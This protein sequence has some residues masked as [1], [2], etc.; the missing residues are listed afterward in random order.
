MGTNRCVELRFGGP[1]KFE[2]KLASPHV[3][4]FTQ[5]I[6]HPEDPVQSYRKEEIYHL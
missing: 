4:F 2:R 1:L 5:C 6:L 3:C